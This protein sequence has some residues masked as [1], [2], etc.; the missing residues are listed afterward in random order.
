M[1]PEPKVT[2]LLSFTQHQTPLQK[3]HVGVGLCVQWGGAGQLGSRNGTHCL[4]HFRTCWY[5]AEDTG[6][7]AEALKVKQFTCV[8]DLA[9]V[10]SLL[11]GVRLKLQFS[12]KGNIPNVQCIFSFRI[13]L[14]LQPGFYFLINFSHTSLLQT[15]IFCCG[16]LQLHNTQQQ[17][18]I[19]SFWKH[20]MAMNLLLIASRYLE[21]LVD[22]FLL[23]MIVL[24]SVVQRSRTLS[25]VCNVSTGG[26]FL[27][28]SVTVTCVTGR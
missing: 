1:V 27:D 5:L 6:E 28:T 9:C 26:Q 19:K 7:L 17:P 22:S 20:A 13:F 4:F 16:I 21:L 23:G 18:I 10:C 11:S 2:L 25:W 24:H 14:T 3:Q 12:S 15:I 8:R